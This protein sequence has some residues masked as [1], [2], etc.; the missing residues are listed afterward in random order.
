MRSRNGGKLF[1]LLVFDEATS[2]LDTI[3]EMGIKDTA[4]GTV[5]Q[6]LNRNKLLR[7]FVVNYL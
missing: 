5:E 4:C 6:N 2:N 3:T 1:L 7:I